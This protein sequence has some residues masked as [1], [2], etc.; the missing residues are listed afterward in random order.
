MATTCLRRS[1]FLLAGIGQGLR[2]F[3]DAARELHQAEGDQAPCRSAGQ[4]APAL[5]HAATARRAAFYTNRGDDSRGQ[6]HHRPDNGNE[7]KQQHSTGK[8]KCLRCG[9]PKHAAKACPVQSTLKCNNCGKQGHL[10]KV[11]CPRRKK[12]RHL[13]LQLQRHLDS[14]SRAQPQPI[15]PLRT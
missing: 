12:H 10:A 8:I 5:Y 6:G 3:A 1:L 9:S 13:V 4:L 14:A 7:K 15:Q 2:H 11:A